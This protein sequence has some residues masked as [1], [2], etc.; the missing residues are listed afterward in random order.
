MPQIRNG[1]GERAPVLR[2]VCGTPGT[3]GGLDAF[4]YNSTSSSGGVQIHFHSN[5]DFDAG[6]GVLLQYRLF[7]AADLPPAFRC[8]ST[9]TRD[10]H[11]TV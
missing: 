7:D 3:N 4:V 5:A 8:H 2:H 6:N 10:T 11:S 9:T 1:I